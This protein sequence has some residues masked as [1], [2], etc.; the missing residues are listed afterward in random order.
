MT[1]EDRARSEERLQAKQ[2]KPRVVSLSVVSFDQIHLGLQ[3]FSCCSFSRSTFVFVLPDEVGS[4]C[5][6]F[7]DLKKPTCFEAAWK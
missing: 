6:A 5:M 2:E 3:T 7:T 1:A 4:F